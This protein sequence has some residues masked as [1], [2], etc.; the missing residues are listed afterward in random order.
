M[1]LKSNAGAAWAV[2]DGLRSLVLSG[3]LVAVGYPAVGR[4]AEAD[5]PPLFKVT[6][7]G[8]TAT[9]DYRFDE[10][11][12]SYGGNAAFSN[13][14]AWQ[15]SLFLNMSSY[16]YHPALLSMDF[17]DVSNVFLLREQRM[18]LMVKRLFSEPEDR[19]NHDDTPPSRFALAL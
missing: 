8:A 1:R 9:V 5:G 11:A 13:Q 7:F 16:V 10:D 19:F 15:E 12:R 4:A 2:G 3:F 14:S 6:D 18:I 17:N